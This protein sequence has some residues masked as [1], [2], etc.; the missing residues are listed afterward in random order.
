MVPKFPFILKFRVCVFGASWITFMGFCFP[1]NVDSLTDYWS[2]K[3][4]L[5]SISKNIKFFKAPIKRGGAFQTQKPVL[6]KEVSHRI[7][8]K[9]PSYLILHVKCSFWLSTLCS[10]IN[11]NSLYTSLQEN[12]C[13]LKWGAQGLKQCIVSHDEE[14]GTIWYHPLAQAH[15]FIPPFLTHNMLLPRDTNGW[16]QSTYP[17]CYLFSFPE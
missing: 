9:P 3:N 17:R 14:P 10:S 4:T 16:R 15:L 8:F 6:T 2:Y 13:C 5:R 11:K 7:A 12:I 1:H